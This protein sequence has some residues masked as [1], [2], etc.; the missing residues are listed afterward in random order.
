M[1][2]QP[3]YY[4]RSRSYPGCWA[5]ASDLRYPGYKTPRVP[6]EPFVEQ[7]A[8]AD[9]LMNGRMGTHMILWGTAAGFEKMIM[10][11]KSSV[12]RFQNPVVVPTM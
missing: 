5:I 1:V 2:A 7:V 12:I 3:F 8:G 4:W 6:P 10:G 9:H 11:P